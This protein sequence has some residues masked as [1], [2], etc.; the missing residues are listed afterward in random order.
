MDR[1]APVPPPPAAGASSHTLL[2]LGFLLST[3]ATAAP[4]FPLFRLLVLTGAIFV[5]VTSEFL[6]TG[7]L[8][9][10]AEELNVSESQ[11]GL[12]VTV[13]AATV[14]LSTAPLTVLTKKLSR[15]WLMVGLLT[16][17]AFANVV[18]A[19][20]PTYEVLVAGRIL[21]GLAHGLF[22]AVTGP[23]VA[24]LVRREQLARAVSIT[25]GGGTV[26]FV[27]GVP[28][29]TALGHA[30][31][32]R[33]SFLVMAVVVLAFTALVVFCL[34]PVSHLVPLATG[35]IAVPTRKDG[36]VPAVLITCTIVLIVVAGQNV[37]YTYIAPWIIEVA[38][39]PADSVGAL[40]FAYGAAGAIGLV[41]AGIFGDRNP[42]A[43]PVIFIIGVAGSV[44]VLALVSDIPWA[45]VAAIVAW[46]IF[47]GGL[48]AIMH[49]RNLR[50]ASPRIRD[51]AAAWLTTS[52]NIGIGGGALLGGVLFDSWGVESLPW[53]Q[54]AI[55][56]A[57]AAFMFLTFKTAKA[58]EYQH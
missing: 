44:M 18:C 12:L 24:L 19:I 41:L 40:L 29:G 21:G 50:A 23:Y 48:P 52:F 25:N 53:V 43:A 57:G 14:V 34:P 13:F 58:R 32:W 54:A 16:V 42:L 39:F 55:V 26:A 3:T 9:D 35:E 4:P 8:V 6:P 27:L 46:S 38:H 47:F 30:L 17:F 11:V 49:A 36:T 28:L 51:E 10:I 20:A 56:L 2:P 15:K 37:F 5:S 31:G 45:V 22:W 7:L 33:L 1:G